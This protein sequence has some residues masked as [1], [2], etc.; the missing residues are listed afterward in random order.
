MHVLYFIEFQCLCMW[1]DIDHFIRFLEFQRAP[2]DRNHSLIMS[3]HLLQQIIGYG[4][5]TFRFLKETVFQLNSIQSII[6]L[7]IIFLLIRLLRKTQQIPI[8][9]SMTRTFLLQR[10]DRDLYLM[11]FVYLRA[12]F[13]E[14]LFMLILNL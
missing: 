14:R 4:S 9:K 1:I 6:I 2:V 11:S 10:L 8:K 3:Y 7:I 12:V 5:E 13:V